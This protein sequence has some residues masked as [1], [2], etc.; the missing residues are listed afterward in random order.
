MISR[1]AGWRI[2]PLFIAGIGLGGFFDGI[3][4]HFLLQWHYFASSR[5]DSDSVSALERIMIVDG[6]FHFSMWIVAAI[7]IYLIWHAARRDLLP[8][9]PHVF[10][11]LILVGWGIFN[12]VDGVLFHL[13]LQLHNAR[14]DGNV[15]L[16]N[17]AWIGWGA[18]FALAGWSLAFN[19][20]RQLRE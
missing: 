5:M 18:L 7:A 19:R 13:V 11:G 17:A 20:Y 3:V 15:A 10:A 12:I 16:W 6:T 8:S 9:R 1:D 4:F 2:Y 14:E